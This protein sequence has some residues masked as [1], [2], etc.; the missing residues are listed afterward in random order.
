MG[1]GWTEHLD[2]RLTPGAFGQP[3]LIAGIVTE[4]T[5]LLPAGLPAPCLARRHARPAGPPTLAPLGRQGRGV[6]EAGR[7]DDIIQEGG[8]RGVAGQWRVLQ[9]EGGASGQVRLGG[10]GEGGEWDGGQGRAQGGVQLQTGVGV[11]KHKLLRVGKQTPPRPLYHTAAVEPWPLSSP[12]L[13]VHRWPCP[14]PHVCAREGGGAGLR[15][16]AGW[17]RG[18]SLGM[19]VCQ[20]HAGLGP[21]GR[22]CLYL[23]QDP[24][25]CNRDLWRDLG[26]SERRKKAW[27]STHIFQN[28]L[29]TS[30]LAMVNSTVSLREGCAHQHMASA[31]HR[32]HTH[33]CG[34]CR[35]QKSETPDYPM[36]PK[37]EVLTTIF[38]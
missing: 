31:V 2:V 26:S 32:E 24:L 23:K 1:G 25:L 34:L 18:R 15:E 22:T 27:Y 6:R 38:S 30:R 36:P 13:Q 33:H 29:H 11:Q 9:R 28:A 5:H 3:C 10:E 37:K 14:W 16:G 19:G 4:V 12:A 8:A 17:D 35:T 20:F 21:G 7:A